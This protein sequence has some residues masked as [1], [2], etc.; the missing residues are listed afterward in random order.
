MRRLF[1][2]FCLSLFL[3]G[4]VGLLHASTTEPE[5][6]TFSVKYKNFEEAVLV[7]TEIVFQ[8]GTEINRVSWQHTL[9]QIT[10]TDIRPVLNS[11]ASA[12]QAFDVPP[13]QVKIQMT[14]FMGTRGTAAPEAPSDEVFHSV[15]AQL[16]QALKYTNYEPLGSLNVLALEGE[17]EPTAVTVGKGYSIEF[18]VDRVDP[19]RNLI[20]LSP[21]VLSRISRDGEG[22]DRLLSTTLT[23]TIGQRMVMVTS[24]GPS[25]DKGLTLAITASLI[26]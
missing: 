14:L 13:R 10:V 16:R 7:V 23:L 2:I 6:R 8:E 19:E 22:T 21:L 9:K 4:S 20:K 24:S 12:L 3:L 11:I 18:L 25:S 15:V 26:E 1:F 17:L 5:T